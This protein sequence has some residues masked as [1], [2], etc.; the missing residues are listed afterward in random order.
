MLAWGAGGGESQSRSFHFK[1]SL[2]GAMQWD[3]RSRVGSLGQKYGAPSGSSP[4][5]LVPLGR[6]GSPRER[7][8]LR[9]GPLETGLVFPWQSRAVGGSGPTPVP[10][11]QGSLSQSAGFPNFPDFPVRGQLIRDPAIW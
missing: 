8:A 5:I 6:E 3:G 1:N 10:G 2:G 9:C 4:R 7:E 11:A